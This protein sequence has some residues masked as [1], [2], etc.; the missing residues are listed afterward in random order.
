M[1]LSPPISYYFLKWGYQKLLNQT[2]VSHCIS[3]GQGYSREHGKIQK[4][5]K[6]CKNWKGR[7]RLITYE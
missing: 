4:R 7:K 2:H 3:I 1:Q 6:R 5:D